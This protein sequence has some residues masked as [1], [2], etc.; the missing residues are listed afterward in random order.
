[1][2]STQGTSGLDAH[3]ISTTGSV[4]W[5]LTAAVLYEH[6]LQRGEG[7]LAAEGP[8][9]CRTGQHTGRSP[10]DKFFVKEPSSEAHI[11][12]GKVNRPLA[13]THFAALRPDVVGPPRNKDLLDKANTAAGAQKWD[14]AGK[15]LEQLIALDPNKQP[16]VRVVTLI[17][18]KRA[19]GMLEHIDKLFSK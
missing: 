4:Y 7:M 9:V 15:S 10:N 11:H 18:Q 2:A 6:A 12:W 17:M 8:L 14:D 3:G 16:S 13:P 1:M 5:N 19:K